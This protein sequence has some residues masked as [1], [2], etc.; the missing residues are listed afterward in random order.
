MTATEYFIL[1]KGREYFQTKYCM[2]TGGEAKAKYS[3]S[4]YDAR[5]YDRER[6]A[7]AE[8]IKQD[9]EIVIFTPL[10][11]TLKETTPIA[12]RKCGTCYYWAAYSGACCNGS[13]EYRA[14]FRL[15]DEG[16]GEWRGKHDKSDL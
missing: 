7:Y 15:S 12:K 9:A 1:R 11:G 14:D 8:A 3:T 5:K 16:C 10:T 13:S 4:P 6:D 2:L